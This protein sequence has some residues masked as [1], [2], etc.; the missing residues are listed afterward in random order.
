MIPAVGQGV[1]CVECRKDDNSIITLLDSITHVK[2]KNLILAERG[3]T[4]TIKGNC[5][6]PLGAH[7]LYIGEDQIKLT[8]FLAS[9]DGKRF[10]KIT[11]IEKTANA[12]ELGQNAANDLLNK[13][14]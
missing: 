2:T 9:E 13:L 11:L 4:E 3:F 1:I 10:D 14:G 7:A 8:A 5:K 12:Y 6:T